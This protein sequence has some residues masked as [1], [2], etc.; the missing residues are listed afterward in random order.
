VF[1]YRVLRKIFGPKRVE[2]RDWE[3]FSNE[4]LHDFH[5][6][7]GIQVIQSRIIRRL[8]HMACMEERRSAYRVLAGKN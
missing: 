4:D 8:G 5:H 1:E 6:S 3:K 7:Q 2:V